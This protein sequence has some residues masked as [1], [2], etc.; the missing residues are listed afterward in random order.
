LRQAHPILLIDTYWDAEGRAVCPAALGLGFHIGPRGTIEPCPPLSFACESIR[1]HDGDLFR[2]INESTFLRGFQQF[3]AE[4]TRGC[5]LL[6]NPSELVQYLRSSGA[7]DASG[8]DA[9]GELI[10]S[11]PRTSH[12][13]PGEEVPETSWLYRFLKRQLFFGMGG[14]G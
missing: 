9:F 12:H 11:L 7:A 2:T 6:E 3:V 8:R 1:D 5:V 13:L 4:R 10:A 14:Y